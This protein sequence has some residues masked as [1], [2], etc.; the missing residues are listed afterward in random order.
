VLVKQK[1]VKGF[2]YENESLACKKMRGRGTGEERSADVSREAGRASLIFGVPAVV[3]YRY[4][5]VP[6]LV[7]KRNFWKGCGT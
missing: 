6:P 1:K 7:R 5:A 2:E 3:C 4:S